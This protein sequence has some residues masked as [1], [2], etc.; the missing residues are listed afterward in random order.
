MTNILW[1]TATNTLTVPSLGLDDDD[2]TRTVLDILLTARSGMAVHIR[3]ENT[4][5]DPSGFQSG[6]YQILDIDAKAGP[7]EVTIKL[8]PDDSDI[9]NEIA[10]NTYTYELSILQFVTG[11]T[12]DNLTLDG[13]ADVDVTTPP[14][15]GQV[16]A[17]DD[18]NS[19]YSPVDNA[20]GGGQSNTDYN[21]ANYGALQD[22]AVSYTYTTET[23][24]TN[25]GEVSIS[26]VDSPDTGH[27]LLF[28]RADV[29]AKALQGIRYLQ[30]GFGSPIAFATYAVAT[31]SLIDLVDPLLVNITLIDGPLDG[32]DILA[33]LPADD[34]ALSINATSNEFEN[35]DLGDL[36]DVSATAPTDNQVLTWNATNSE[37]EPQASQSGGATTLN[38]LNDVNTNGVGEGF[39]IRYDDTN[40]NWRA[41]SIGDTN[42][43]HGGVDIDMPSGFTIPSATGTE[44]IAIGYNAD[45]SGAASI[46]IGRDSITTHENATA[47]GE[48]ATTDG[49]NEVRLGGENVHVTIDDAIAGNETFDNQLAS[50]KYVKDA[51][52]DASRIV[53][54]SIDGIYYGVREELA[55]PWS[56]YEI[57]PFLADAVT[58][59]VA[60][61]VQFY[62]YSNENTNTFEAGVFQRVS[63]TVDQD[64]GSDLTNNT[65]PDFFEEQTDVQTD[66]NIGAVGGEDS[67]CLGWKYIGYQDAK[68]WMANPIGV[69]IQLRWVNHD[70]E[71]AS[72]SV[73]Q[74]GIR[75]EWVRIKP[76][77]IGDATVYDISDTD[78]VTSLGATTNQYY[79][80]GT[81]IAAGDTQAH[82]I[83][84]VLP[85]QTF[86]DAVTIS[87]DDVIAFRYVIF[88][89]GNE[90]ASDP[91][92]DSG[93]SLDIYW[94][95]LGS[96][97]PMF[98]IETVDVSDQLVIESTGDL[99]YTDNV[100]G[101]TILVVDN[102]DGVPTIPTASLGLTAGNGIGISGDDIS[103]NAAASGG[104]AVGSGGVAINPLPVSGLALT[105]SGVAVNPG[106]GLTLNASSQVQVNVNPTN[107]SLT[108]DANGL[109]VNVATNGGLSHDTDGN[110]HIL[111]DPLI[112]GPLSL[113]S[114][115]L[116][117]D[118]DINELND[119]T[120][121]GT[122]TDGQVL[123]Y[124]ADTSMWV[125]ATIAG[126]GSFTAG[127]G[128]DLTDA[129]VLNLS[130]DLKD[131]QDTYDT[132]NP[133]EGDVL[134]WD[135]TPGV[136][137]FAAPAAANQFF[138]Y[139]AGTNP[140]AADASATDALAIGD[141]AVAGAANSIAIGE[142]SSANG[143]NT[144]ALGSNATASST[145][146]SGVA[147]GRSAS[148]TSDS[149]I[150]IGLSS[151]S[152]SAR[153]IAL[154]VSSNAS[155]SEGVAIGDV[156]TA[157]GARSVAMGNAAS[158]TGTGSVAIGD[159]ASATSSGIVAIGDGAGAS[160]TDSIAIGN[161][162][163]VAG[164][165]AIA[166]G[167]D[168]ST[169][170]NSLG[171][172]IGE[173]ATVGAVRGIAIGSSSNS[174]AADAD[175]VTASGVNSIAIGRACQASGASGIAI[176]DAAS[177]NF[178]SAIALG[179]G[180]TAT[181]SNRAVVGTGGFYRLFTGTREIHP[182]Q[183]FTN[184]DNE[185][186]CTLSGTYWNGGGFSSNSTGN[187][188]LKFMETDS[189]VTG[190]FNFTVAGASSTNFGVGDRWLI[191]S[192]S[193]PM[194]SCFGFDAGDSRISLGTFTVTADTSAAGVMG[195]W[196][197]HPNTDIAQIVA[198][199]RV[200]HVWGNVARDE[201]IS[202][203]FSLLK[204]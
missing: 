54:D 56:T 173:R 181:G 120:I 110:I 128:L 35:P 166:I 17:W 198:G 142:S 41:H 157:S 13:L 134:T 170:S 25:E 174:S 162:A 60:T 72:V 73:P 167:S 195:Q 175:L 109:A 20:G 139:F 44:A 197:L 187:E 116:K 64:G 122:P 132:G 99:R 190:R 37:W 83:T 4:T 182:Q 204:I 30:I 179:N 106:P 103:V 107:S 138:D 53:S 156:A 3:Q 62:D 111:T 49:N 143:A 131:L 38:G 92:N 9:F 45:A 66:N 32:D 12:L 105:A 89:H 137:T 163:G 63:T 149:S 141:T 152:S 196:Y 96:N 69:P 8:L 16:L 27:A 67:T 148:S 22:P 185:I 199:F 94:Q 43:L 186:S 145:S 47:I 34:T 46:A 151:Q 184:T 58:R 31:T 57:D 2:N 93:L 82:D 159:A 125:N 171:I 51:V 100:S 154:G 15:D 126:G 90:F 155:G 160:G 19:V 42:R 91:A 85:T 165:R 26:T 80:H 124:D 6:F 108:A 97:N 172:A 146:A 79:D 144:V 164:T 180:A 23:S 21:N 127:L 61:S 87:D 135:S 84:F 59:Q 129:S 176:G 28:R 193:A 202:A 200:Y 168:P 130:A 101:N 48:N 14:T 118:A 76:Q 71:N 81:T 161:S 52:S 194:L 36:P 153:A 50:V 191:N 203:S 112:S 78:F 95:A 133:S 55:D 5:S 1:D 183:T 113:S 98:G 40:D 65:I 169:G 115:G 188:N 178:S 123:E 201:V 33:S 117:W 39:I 121:T 75:L 189:H 7:D 70:T 102:V 88:F 136:W 68:V 119:V 158:S 150:S 140:T 192:S 147:I 10:G 18:T 86:S 11:G 114:E 29:D 104:L 177:A 24:P 77:T 74:V